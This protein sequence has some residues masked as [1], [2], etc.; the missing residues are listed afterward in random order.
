[1]LTD[2]AGSGKIDVDLYFDEIKDVSRENIASVLFEIVTNEENR[3][4]ELQ[5]LD[6]STDVGEAVKNFKN[7]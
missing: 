6:G 5:I 4:K 7:K 2:E 1:M 3:G